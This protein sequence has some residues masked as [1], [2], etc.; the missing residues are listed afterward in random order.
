MAGHRT[1]LSRIQDG[2][3]SDETSGK[4]VR[5]SSANPGRVSPPGQRNRRRS[6]PG[7]NGRVNARRRLAAALTGLVSL[8]LGLTTMAYIAYAF[9]AS[10]RNG[11]GLTVVLA[12]VLFGIPAV[13]VG[14]LAWCLRKPRRPT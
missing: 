1:I 6:A 5:P 9:D 12:L 11:S 4:A 7:D 13:T 8:A 3:L 14:T 10:N 2:G